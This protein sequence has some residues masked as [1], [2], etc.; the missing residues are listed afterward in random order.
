M[1]MD[2]RTRGRPMRRIHVQWGVAMALDA[3]ALPFRGAA[4]DF[5]IVITRD[6]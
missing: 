2:A 6:E 5:T 1:A 3:V 4:S